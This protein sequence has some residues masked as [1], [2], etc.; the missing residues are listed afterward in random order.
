M[1]LNAYDD[2]KE[3]VNKNKTWIDVKNKTLLSRE[4]QYRRVTLLSKRYNI[5]SKSY[6]Y[7]II[8]LD[9]EPLDRDYV[10]T[11]RDDYGRVKIRLTKIWHD[12][13]LATF[14]ANC[15]IGI[16]HIDHTDDGD[17]YQLDI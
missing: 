6:D 12:S 16:Q 11:N 5:V 9:D 7:F 8:M 10:L 2:V 13:S 14:D 3:Q 15:N 4:I 1:N 17:V